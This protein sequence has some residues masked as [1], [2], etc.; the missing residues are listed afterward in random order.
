MT[1]KISEVIESLIDYKS[2]Y[3]DL[4]VNYYDDEILEEFPLLIDTYYD[5]NYTNRT[6]VMSRGN[7]LYKNK[8]RNTSIC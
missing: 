3:G 5:D 1:I 4:E 7:E 6:I 2:K 8:N